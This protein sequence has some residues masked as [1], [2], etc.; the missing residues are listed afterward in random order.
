[1]IKVI[2]QKM[3]FHFHTFKSDPQKRYISMVTLIKVTPKQMY[4]HFHI[5]KGN[6]PKRY[7]F[8]FT[9]F[10]F[11]W[12]LP[13]KPIES[14]IIT[15]RT[16]FPCLLIICTHARHSLQRIITGNTHTHTHAEET[17]QKSSYLTLSSIRDTE[18]SW[19]RMKRFPRSGLKFSGTSVLPIV[20]GGEGDW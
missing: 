1:M 16:D 15:L 6:K 3:Y 2:P 20:P 18:E 9:L 10:A 8:T 5:F 12:I 14:N 11:I 13:I 4:F 7:I 17:P 19:P